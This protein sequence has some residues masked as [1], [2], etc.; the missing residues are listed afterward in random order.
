MP[1]RASGH[2]GSPN[3]WDLGRGR[4][5]GV[6][7]RESWGPGELEEAPSTVFLPQAL[8]GW[9]GLEEKGDDRESLS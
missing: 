5:L 7:W 2:P 4:G 9:V 8:L 3:G 6:L 1:A